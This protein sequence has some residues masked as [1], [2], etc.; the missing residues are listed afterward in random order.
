MDA[1]DVAM[2]E[3]DGEDDIRIGPSG[4]FH[5]PAD[6]RDALLHLISD[7]AQ[8]E[9]GDLTDIERAVTD[10]HCNAVEEFL[11]INKIPKAQ[12]DLVGFHGQTVLHKPE[13]RVTH[14]ILDGTYAAAR[15]QI[16]CVSRFRHRDVAA[17]GQGAPLAP[18]Y[19]QARAREL[20]KPLAILNLGGVA[21]V[22]LI[23]EHD[24]IAFDTG[25]ASALMDDMMRKIR[26]V[27]FDD[28]GAIACSGTVR[29]DI[30]DAFLND[31][32]FSKLPPKSLDRN[33]FHRWAAYVEPLGLADAMA[34]LLAFTVESIVKSR[35]HAAARPHRWLVGGGGRR[36]S[37]LMQ[38]LRERLHVPVEPVEV[39]GWNG[40][41]LEAECFAW[42]A[43]RSIRGLPLSL[44]STTGVPEPMT[45]GVLDYAGRSKIP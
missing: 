21:N 17:G 8:I 32:Y 27:D 34:T 35:D 25:P 36:N 29:S 4:V 19:H 20:P 31:P 11:T 28:D 38:R 9:Q 7:A 39:V 42:L 24:I 43:I 30:L 40:D 22:T 15:L 44:P 37:F 26:G 45:G 33:A 41:M 23:N 10:A 5:Y 6:T 18:L 16:D 12:I 14:Q 2:I 1:I 3:S 13:Q